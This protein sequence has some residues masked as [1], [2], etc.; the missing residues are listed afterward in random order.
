[1]SLGVVRPAFRRQRIR[2]ISTVFFAVLLLL[3]AV[4]EIYDPFLVLYLDDLV[5]PKPSPAKLD[6]SNDVRF[7][8]YSDTRPHIGKIDLLQKGLVLVVDGRPVIEEA[9]GFGLPIVKYGDLAYNAR[10]ATVTQVDTDTLVKRFIIDTEDRWS[11][12]LRVKYKAVE[13]L[14][15]VVCTYTIG[16]PDTISVTVDFSNLMIAWDAAYLMN[17]QGARNFPIYEDSAGIRQH[18]D[19]LGIWHPTDDVYGCWLT[20]DKSLRFCVESEPGQRRFVGRERYN[21]YNWV[22]I[23]TLSW[24]GIDIEIN[25]PV[26]R[27]SYVIRV[28]TVEE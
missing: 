27:Y 10:H 9:Y 16:P 23:Y 11:R 3:L 21:Q 24:S 28:Q 5:H 18:G 20:D 13:P 4:R 26:E 25:E 19:A 1:M 2:R 6:L 22:A 17:E 14:G 12:F 15:T 7:L 8:L